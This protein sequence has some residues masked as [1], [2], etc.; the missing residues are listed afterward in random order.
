MGSRRESDGK[1]TFHQPEVRAVARRGCCDHRGG[2]R[3]EHDGQGPGCGPEGH[4][5]GL[6]GIRIPSVCGKTDGDH[7]GRGD[8]G[9]AQHDRRG[10][11]VRLQGRYGRDT[12]VHG[13][14]RFRDGEVRRSHRGRYIPGC[15]RG[16]FGI[17]RIRRRS[18][19]PD[20]EREPHRQDKQDQVL[21]H[22]YPRLLE[23]GGTA[24]PQARRQVHRRA[25]LLQAH[26]IRCQD[27]AGGDGHQ[28]RGLRLRG[29]PPA[30]RQVPHQ[31]G[32]PAGIHQRADST[33][34]PD[35]GD[36]EHLQRSRPPRTGF[37]AGRGEAR[38]QDIRHIIRIRCGERCVRH[39]RHRQHQDL[40]EGERADG[41]AEDG[42][43]RRAGLRQIRDVQGQDSP[44][45]RVR[46]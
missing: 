45:G 22:R 35:T 5:S 13:A 17:F 25:R 18:G 46:S 38:R 27:N 1:G 41:R 28:A 42:Q 32:R 33:G 21:H 16:C 2:G 34:S 9:D 29:V 37:R 20:R 44:A 43:H 26:H 6:R 40:Q 39:H 24:L 15:S 19:I 23:E 30:Q 31:G 36:R 7:S 14:G 12:G 3:Q 11:G 4:R 8:Q 10:H